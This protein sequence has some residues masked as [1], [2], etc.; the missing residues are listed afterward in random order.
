MCSRHH[1][2]ASHQVSNSTYIRAHLLLGNRQN[3]KQSKQVPLKRTPIAVRLEHALPPWP[4]VAARRAPRWRSSALAQQIAPSSISAPPPLSQPIGL[5]RD[6]RATCLAHL[7]KTS[8]P[9]HPNA[10]GVSM[11][12]RS[13]AKKFKTIIRATGANRTSSGMTLLSG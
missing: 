13:V 5:D 11:R 10:A 12:L 4:S 8:Y 6:P 7:S 2:R 9:A 3:S 1:K